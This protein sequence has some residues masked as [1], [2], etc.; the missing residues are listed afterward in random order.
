MSII[1]DHFKDRGLPS[2]ASREV[3]R[4]TLSLFSAFDSQIKIILPVIGF[5]MFINNEKSK[6]LLGLKYD[7]DLDQSLIE[8]VEA[9]IEHGI[10]KKG[11][12]KS[13]QIF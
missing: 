13:C 12:K 4:K 5:Q 11:N 7:R 8:M 3:G 6:K 1:R 9:M 10:L 2:V